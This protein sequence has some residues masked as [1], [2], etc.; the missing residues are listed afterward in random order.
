M[1][2]EEM[3]KT[4][5]PLDDSIVYLN[6]AA[7]S[8][9]PLRTAEAIHQF[10]NENT[11]LGATNYLVWLEK[12]AE[13]RHQMKRLINAPSV[14][15]IALLKNT[16]EALS[17]VAEGIDW[18]DG[19]NI[20][21][22]DEEFPSNKLPWN[23]QAKYGVEFREVDLSQGVSPEA[24]LIAACDSKTRVLT[25]SS[26]QYGSGKCPD[27]TILGEYCHANN[28]L[29]CVDAIQ[30]LGCL[31]FDCQAIK[32]DFVMADAHKWMLG[33]EGIA[34]FYCKAE[35]RDSLSLHQYG[36]HMVKD[37]GNYDS[38]EIEYAD[39]A[40]R[41]ECG[42]PNMLGIHALSASLSLIEEIGMEKIST[43][44]INNVGYL[45]DKFE[46]TPGLVFVSPTT[47]PHYAG[48]VT[49]RIE[50]I[51]MPQLYSKLMKN[52]LICANRAGG[53]RFSPHFYTSRE[54][55]D[56]SLEILSLSI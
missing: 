29:F 35:V 7:V 38:T 1:S 42:S 21:S 16:S 55:I 3:F 28:I 18:Q 53:I 40:R 36:W 19:D 17:V 8:P 2:T 10:A 46:D 6:H 14:D 12:E 20:V 56:K 30:S 9:W 27:L 23:A 54:S 15:D 33:P 47:K 32:A 52:K 11:L 31:P 48:I 34:L 49:F 37:V 22:S 51:N 43:K 4:E 25:I 39:T 50:G 44:I 26:V 45:I 5:F 13:L 41:F 24:A